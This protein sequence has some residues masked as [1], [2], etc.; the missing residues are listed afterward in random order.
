MERRHVRE[1]ATID[2]LI[3]EVYEK[4]PLMMSALFTARR[5][6]LGCP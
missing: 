5:L 3:D 6:Q 1:K 2:H 4:S